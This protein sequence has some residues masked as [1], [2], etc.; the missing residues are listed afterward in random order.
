M[1][2]TI[3]DFVDN[4]FLVYIYKKKKARYNNLSN[5]WVCV[6]K[7]TSITI[8][9]L[10]SKKYLKITFLKKKNFAHDNL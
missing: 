2:G 10:Q 8:L 9:L 4:F 1:L 5:K 6:A 7:T 3:T